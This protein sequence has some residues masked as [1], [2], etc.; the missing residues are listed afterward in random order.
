VT[1]A[2][3]DPNPAPRFQRDE[4]T[5]SR[6]TIDGVVLL[7]PSASE[8]LVLEGAAAAMWEL[9]ATPMTVAGLVRELAGTYGVDGA[10]ITDDVDRTVTTL[11]GAGALCRR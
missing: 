7:A 8:P 3:R 10:T 2:G 9:L 1:P 4:A 5:L 11:S 6:R